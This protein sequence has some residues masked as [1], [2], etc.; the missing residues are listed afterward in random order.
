MSRLL[1]CLYTGVWL[2]VC[3]LFGTSLTMAGTVITDDASPVTKCTSYTSMAI[4]T[5]GNVTIAGCTLSQINA[6]FAVTAATT[7]TVGTALPVTVTRTIASGGTAGSDTLTLTTTLAG[8]F[9]PAAVSF[10][11]ADGAVSTKPSS[12]TFSAAGTAT[13]SATG[14]STVTSSSPITVSLQ[15]T[16]GCTNPISST[17]IGLMPSGGG[18]VYD[19]SNPIALRFRVDA[20]DS[21][22]Q[23]YSILYVDY[24]PSTRHN[25]MDTVISTC[26][27]NFSAFG[28][29]GT[30]SNCIQLNSLGAGPLLSVKSNAHCRVDPN[31]DYYI[32]IRPASP[33]IDSLFVLGIT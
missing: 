12:I 32:N 8:T 25:S 26:P 17:Y 33:N 2:G 22:N 21:V 14:A 11:G 15:S 9:T 16:S 30:A 1:S 3:L 28:M 4:N 23:L 13:L 29:L 31:T 18:I 10:T 24:V 6:T 20:A 7:A 27:G 19:I 5:V